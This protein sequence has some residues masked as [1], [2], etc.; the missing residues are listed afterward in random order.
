MCA[1]IRRRF[2]SVL[3][4]ERAYLAD[5]RFWMVQ[6][7][8]LGLVGVHALT[9]RLRLLPENAT[10]YFFPEAMFL[11]PVGYAALNFGFEGSI[12]TA[13]WSTLLAVP[14]I[15]IWHRGAQLDG[16][17]L[18]LLIVNAV[19][20]FV[21][22]RVDRE[23]QARQQVEVAREALQASE[24]RYRSLFETS[25]DAVVV[26]TRAGIVRQANRAAAQLFG[27]PMSAL[28]ETP[29][30]EL[31][32]ED[33]ARRL[34]DPQSAGPAEFVLVRPD[35]DTVHLDP[36]CTVLPSGGAE[37]LV[38]A[39]L[40][41]VTEQH[42]KQ[43][44]LQTYARHILRAQE[45]ERRRIAQELHDDVLQSLIILLRRLNALEDASPPQAQLHTDLLGARHTAGEL[46]A[47]VRG[48]A[49][50]LRPPALEALGLVIS[51]RRLLG[52]VTY[53]TMITGDLVIR[54]EERRLGEDVEL[55][56]FRIAQEALRNVERHAEASRILISLTF[57]PSEVELRVTDNGRGFATGATAMGADEGGLGLLGMKERAALLG[58]RFC[59]ESAPRKGTTV[60]I[61]VR[62]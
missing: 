1:R 28:P 48:F 15:L 39:L 42:R 20:V 9:E 58:G 46:I 6:L 50:Q 37:V 12:A 13:L 47:A 16:V 25:A 11:I 52:E 22:G 8:V 36:M 5:R 19:A 34:V 31:I 49:R 55:G 23:V 60:S 56:L 40:R 35:H 18:Q 17:L 51:L 30:A 33:H 2:R 21:G 10:L 57:V 59:V 14:N 27:R 44:E 61:V 7:L 4:H 3:E 62:G 38:Q 24:R 26:F 43:R 41:D 32:G 45:D 29:L 54:G 53:R